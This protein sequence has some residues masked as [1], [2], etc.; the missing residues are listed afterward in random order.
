[1]VDIRSRSPR[2]TQLFYLE[3]SRFAPT[4]QLKFR[5]LINYIR[6]SLHG[7]LSMAINPGTL[8]LFP[9]GLA[10]WLRDRGKQARVASF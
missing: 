2:G 8:A 6:F 7:H 4:A 5:A 3:Q 1:M 10:L 9:A